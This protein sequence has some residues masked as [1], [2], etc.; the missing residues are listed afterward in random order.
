M[1]VVYHRD[2]FLPPE[3]VQFLSRSRPLLFRGSFPPITPIPEDLLISGYCSNFR[4]VSLPFTYIK[5]KLI[6]TF[7]I[8]DLMSS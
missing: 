7:C 1:A 8:R 4:K 3:T 6:L 2:S 5:Y